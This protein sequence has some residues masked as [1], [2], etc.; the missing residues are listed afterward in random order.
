MSNEAKTT[1]AYKI[2]PELK[3]KLERLAAESGLE[4]QEAFIEQL[5]A[6]YELQ[7]L[8]E[9]SGSG[10]AKQIEEYEYHSRRG[11]ELIVSIVQT[12]AAERLQLSQQHE[13]KQAAVAAELFAQQ[14][15]IAELRKAAKAQAE[16]LARLAKENE[17]QAR[18]I[19]QLEA[20]ARD[21]GLL[22]DQYREKVDTLSG[23]VN[24]YKA[25]AEENKD[26]K[27]DISRLTGITEKQGERAAALE[28]DLAAMD[29]LRAE[30]LRQAEERQR[31]A[32][33]LLTKQKEAEKKEALADLRERQQD[34]LEKATE[35]IRTLYAQIEQLRKGYEQ[36]IREIQQPKDDGKT[37]PAKK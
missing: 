2:S 18:L 19:E 11:A 21:K 36:Q 26:L 28:A 15:E 35:E 37:P 6:L 16:E 4:T 22:V 3:E 33:E 13:E 10:Y 31:E 32:L 8:K 27:T 20:A 9:G 25:A 24:E 5:A 30:Q 14:D 34:K 1:K 12:E 17:A 29:E 7:Q 23:L